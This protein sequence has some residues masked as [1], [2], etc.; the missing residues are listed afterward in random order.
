MCGLFLIGSLL[1]GRTSEELAML[2]GRAELLSKA[3]LKVEYLSSSS[4][5]SKEPAL[6]VGGEYGAAFLPDDFQ[7]DAFRSVAFLEKVPLP[8]LVYESQTLVDSYA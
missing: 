8:D 4:L 5:L 6:E 1:I 7:L 3:G 2:E